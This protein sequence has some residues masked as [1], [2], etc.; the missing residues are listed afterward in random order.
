MDGKCRTHIRHEKSVQIF[1][2]NLKGIDHLE[3]LGTDRRTIL[4]H[5]V[6]GCKGL[7]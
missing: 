1:A 3:D 7:D 2:N 6:V 5:E 4:N